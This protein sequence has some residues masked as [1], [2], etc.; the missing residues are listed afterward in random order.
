MTHLTYGDVQ[1]RA[2]HAGLVMSRD[3]RTGA[4]NLR[5]R[6]ASVSAQEW[7]GLSLEEALS[8]IPSTDDAAVER[9]PHCRAAVGRGTER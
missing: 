4:I 1:V 2:A 5:Y 3:R 8:V 7:R 9:C 6:R